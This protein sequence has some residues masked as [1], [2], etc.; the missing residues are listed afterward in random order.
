MWFLVTNCT[1]EKTEYFMQ[2]HV[3]VLDMTFNDFVLCFTS[4]QP[5]TFV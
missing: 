5:L 2:K 3:L 1:G 4:M